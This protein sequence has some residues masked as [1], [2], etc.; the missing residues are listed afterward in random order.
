MLA[1]EHLSIAAF[2]FV[3]EAFEWCFQSLLFLPTMHA[4]VVDRPSKG[5]VRFGENSIQ[6]LGEYPHVHAS[7]LPTIP[8][9]RIAGSARDRLEMVVQAVRGKTGT[10]IRRR[11]P[12]LVLRSVSLHGPAFSDS[13]VRGCIGQGTMSP[14]L[15]AIYNQL[16]G[17]LLQ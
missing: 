11:A 14:I 1:R 5:I 16:P 17:W 15:H 4:A 2:G 12:M 13:T 6:R 3:C 7:P 8:A 10:T 9:P